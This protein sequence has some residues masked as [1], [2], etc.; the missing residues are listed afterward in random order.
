MDSSMAMPSAAG[1]VPYTVRLRATSIA[2]SIKELI[3]APMSMM[4]EVMPIF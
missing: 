4:P 3:E 2:L 1:C